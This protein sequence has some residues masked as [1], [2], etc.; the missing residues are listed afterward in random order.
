MLEDNELIE[1]FQEGEE[2]VFDVLVKRYSPAMVN[3]FYRVCWQRE[4]AED[5]A[6]EVFIKLYRN[7]GRFSTTGS[8]KA[9]IYKIAKNVWID[10]LRSK[11]GQSELSKNVVSASSEIVLNNLKSREPSAEE[12]VYYNE[13]V[14]ILQETVNQLSEEHKMAFMLYQDDMKYSEIAEVLSI[15]EGTVKSRLH[16][17]FNKLKKAL[18][19]ES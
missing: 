19:E 6:Q 5:L 13:K 15:P 8:F 14:E 18:F 9:Y 4:L 11:K 7:L 1:L 16:H 12:V 3:F 17:V 10:F 2:E